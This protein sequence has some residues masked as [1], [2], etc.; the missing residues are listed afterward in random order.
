MCEDFPC[1]N[2]ERGC[3]PDFDSSGNQ[4]NMVCTC[5][6]KLPISSRFSICDSCLNKNE[7]GEPLD[8]IYDDR[9]IYEDDNESYDASDDGDALASAGW[10][11]DEDYNHGEH[12]M[13]FSFED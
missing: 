3:C 10:G 5:G 7:D 11:T 1:C 12:D 2:H 9:D 4:L 13:D 8:D 6:K